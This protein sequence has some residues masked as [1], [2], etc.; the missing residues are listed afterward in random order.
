M[1]KA[2]GFTF[3]QISMSV[4]K[5]K[6]C[7]I[8]RIGTE[9]IPLLQDTQGFWYYTHND[10]FSEHF[11]Y[12]EDIDVYE[13]AEKWNLKGKNAQQLHTQKWE[14]TRLHGGSIGYN[15]QARD[16]INEW[17]NHTIKNDI[18]AR[19]IVLDVGISAYTSNP[20]NL[21]LKGPSGIGK[22]YIALQALKSFPEEDKVI[23]GDLSPKALVHDLGLAKFVD[24]KGVEISLTNAPDIKSSSEEKRNWRERLKNARYVID[25]SMK[26]IVFLEIP[27]LETFQIL[28][29][30]LSHDK[31]EIEFKI[32]D[33]T[34]KGN[35]STK[36][37]IIRGWPATIFCTSDRDYIEDL[38]T[39]SFTITPQVTKEKLKAAN[40]LTAHKRAQPWLYEEDRELPYM[41]DYIRRIKKKLIEGFKITIPFAEYL[42]EIFPSE[43][44]RDM[45]DF[46]HILSLIECSTYLHL[47]HRPILRFNE[48]EYLIAT[49][50][51]LQYAI[52]TFKEIA[53]TTR[54][55]L[56]A[57]ILQ[58]YHVVETFEEPPLYVE[59][60]T[61]YNEL[62]T[63]KIS[64]STIYSYGK[65][66]QEIG[67]LDIIYDEFDRRKR[68]LK[69]LKN[70][71]I[72]S[73]CHIGIFT[74][75]FGEKEFKKWLFDIE[76]YSFYKSKYL[77][78]PTYMD[79]KDV[80]LEEEER[81]DFILQMFFPREYFQESTEPETK[82]FD[83]KENVNIPLGE[84]GTFPALSTTS[85]MITFEDMRR[86]LHSDFV[87]IGI[88]S[89]DAWIDL[90]VSH[91]GW[92]KEYAKKSFEHTK[93][94]GDFEVYGD[95][96]LYQYV[97]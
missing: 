52:D 68:R 34:S 13:L 97:G 76:N 10:Q 44:G 64:S 56:D 84:Y 12:Y 62:Y 86:D 25:L 40:M 55:G 43:Q 96:G 65:Q 79:S 83:E 22:T 24:S 60:I 38:S 4:S 16:R 7:R 15:G 35:L 39:R 48:E 21:I 46:D 59:V 14:L 91:T 31:Y 23:L 9:P 28:R 82:F 2:S 75:L 32:T 53:E 26:I 33:K 18:A 41:Q 89:T 73:E 50:L 95:S 81:I 71:E 85:S 42:T 49:F 61:K 54:T 45:R 30:L 80:N 88:S 69:I 93:S 63:P 51:D 3:P 20:L 92:D 66:L 17:M 78:F 11:K 87:K 27:R 5:L 47:Y 67:W 8:M 74:S 94:L 36:T 70:P 77:A 37:V 29:P 90:I 19:N 1:V 58:F 6:R 57:I 72:V